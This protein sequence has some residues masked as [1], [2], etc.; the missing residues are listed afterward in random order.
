MFK[1]LI[2]ILSL[3]FM[4]N[5]TAQEDSPF[6][7]EEES[8]D[9]KKDTSETFEYSGNIGATYLSG[10]DKASRQITS[11]NIY[12]SKKY[13]FAKFYLS[14]EAYSTVIEYKGKKREGSQRTAPEKTLKYDDDGF[15]LRDAYAS[16][17]LRDNLTLNAGR[18]VIVW[19]QFDLFSP[20][21]YALPYKT[22]TTGIGFSKVDSRLPQ[23]LLKLSYY[24]TSKFEI[25]LY[26]IPKIATDP[27]IDKFTENNYSYLDGD[28][29]SDGH[30]DIITADVEKPQGSEER[31]S[32]IRLMYYP[33]W[34]TVGLTYYKG[35]DT[36]PVE[37]KEIKEINGYLHFP[38]KP[39]ITEKKLLGFEIAK[40]YGK[41]VYKL[42][43][44][45]SNV[46]KS[47]NSPSSSTV[48][49]NTEEQSKKHYLNWIQS[50]NNNKLYADTY[51]NLFAI[52]F[53]RDTEN[54]LMNIAI[55]HLRETPQD[56]KA[57]EAIRRSDDSGYD[58]N[59]FGGAT[60]PAFNIARKYGTN[61]TG[62]IGLAAGILGSKAGASLYITN[63]YKE[64]LT[65]SI[66]A[67]YLMFNSDS[68]LSDAEYE[69]EDKAIAGLGASLVY[70]F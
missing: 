65:W 28:L 36:F 64:S 24:P 30:N 47:L 44:A 60:A 1:K 20:I 48:N 70:N 57:K 38:L 51:W 62:L 23:D 49:I 18:Q 6:E 66:S 19:G 41:S 56:D 55:F 33:S 9:D 42:E 35:W 54:W 22:S 67:N 29:D 25:Q 10:G 63:K 32:A 27:L 34:G 52:G 39:K 12:L 68:N 53:D 4:F 3:L 45:R 59:D 26:Y 15:E 61:K 58:N 17:Y 7:I 21:D 69:I 43:Y 11:A 2:T 46:I 31:Q 13:S 5:I 16:I 14:G 37:R 40:P 50:D 8:K